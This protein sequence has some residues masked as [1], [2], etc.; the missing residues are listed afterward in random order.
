MSLWLGNVTG[1][2][3]GSLVAARLVSQGSP[4]ASASLWFLVGV[5]WFATAQCVVVTASSGSAWAATALMAPA[6]VTTSALALMSS[7]RSS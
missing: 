2:V 4:L 5:S 6:T 1:F 3:G 7:P